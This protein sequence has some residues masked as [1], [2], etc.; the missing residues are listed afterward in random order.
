MNN[1]NVDTILIGGKKKKVVTNGALPDTPDPRDKKLRTGWD[2]FSFI[3]PTI[4]VGFT[5][6]KPWMGNIRDQ[7]PDGACTGFATVAA[8]EALMYHNRGIV[9]DLSE[10]MAYNYAKEY[11]EWPGNSYEG[12]SLRGC[13]KGVYKHGV[14]GESMWPYNP[15]KISKPNINFMK[16]A[17]RYRI[18]A[19]KSLSFGPLGNKIDPYEIA[20][21]LKRSPVIIAMLLP[22]TFNTVDKTGIVAASA[23]QGEMGHAMCITGYNPET[24]LFQI[25]NSWGESWGSKGYCYMNAGLVKVCA[26][27]AWTIRL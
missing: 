13:L 3:R 8:I 14:C 17:F 2:L 23:P 7:G 18:K 4:G 25:R 26:F 11:D 6:W 5:D 1:L 22:S 24:E 12:S 10:E 15:M 16:D 20:R 27:S 19:Y 21:A 9:V